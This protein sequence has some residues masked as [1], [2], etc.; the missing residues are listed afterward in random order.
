MKKVA[1]ICALVMTVSLVP[2]F[3]ADQINNTTQQTVQNQTALNNQTTAQEK[4]KNCTKE[5][6]TKTGSCDCDEQH[7]Y[8]NGQKNGKSVANLGQ[9]KYQNGQ[10]NT[11]KVA[12]AKSTT[13]KKYQYGLK[14]VKTGSKLGNNHKNCPNN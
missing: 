4:L 10:K 3:A 11:A 13:Q 7:K 1:L 12:A 5:N 8:Q 14:N 2:I 6:C 9:H